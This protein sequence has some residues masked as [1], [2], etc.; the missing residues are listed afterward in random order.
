MTQW[1]GEYRGFLWSFM[2]ERL[3]HWAIARRLVGARDLCAGMIARSL[4]VRCH[5]DPVSARAHLTPPPGAVFPESLITSE[6]RDRRMFHCGEL[7]L[8]AQADAI[9]RARQVGRSIRDSVPPIAA[10]FLQQQVMVVIATQDSSAQAFATALAGDPGFVETPRPQLIRIHASPPIQD[11]AWANL[12]HRAP[13]GLVAVDFAA[14]RRMRVNGMGYLTDSGI[15][16]SCVE[17]YS[18]C[19]RHITTRAL[20]SRGHRER[21]TARVISTALTAHQQGWISKSDTFFIATSHPDTG[22]DVSHKGGTPGFVHVNGVGQIVF[23][24]YPGNFLFNTL[25]NIRVNPESV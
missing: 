4:I 22:M 17:V 10:K 2:L 16:L 3:H 7:A 5:F 20:S 15:S 25:G 9:D 14:H 11:P 18:N 23:P 24:D 12:A 13:M 21:P 6:G 8:Q 19:G 1:A